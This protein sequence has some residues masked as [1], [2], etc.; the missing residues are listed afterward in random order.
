[1]EAGY[2]V[3]CL[4]SEASA[5][6]TAFKAYDLNLKRAN[7]FF[8]KRDQGWYGD[9][10]EIQSLKEFAESVFSVSDGLNFF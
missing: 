3:R 7:W 9:K 6:P 8:P 5:E 2:N 10:Q 4:N 1:V